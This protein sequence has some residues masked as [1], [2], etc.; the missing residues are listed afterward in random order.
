MDKQQR[1]RY[2][3]VQEKKKKKKGHELSSQ[4]ASY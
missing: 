3:T 4:E 2:S 1:A